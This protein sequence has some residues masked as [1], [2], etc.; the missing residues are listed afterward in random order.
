MR[1][2]VVILV[3]LAACGDDNVAR[4]AAA[5]PDAE[6][7]TEN[8][9]RDV[10]ETALTFDLTTR[11]ATA[12]ITL[13]PSASRV[14]S[15]EVGD[16]TIESVVGADGA[17][18]EVVT[19]PGGILHVHFPAGAEPVLDVAYT[20]TYHENNQGA[21]PT[22]G[23]TLLWPYY[24]GNLFP[25]KNRETPG[26]G[27][28]FTLELTG[29]PDGVTAV[30]PPAIAAESPSYMIAWALDAYDELPLGT[31]TAGTEVVMWHL[32][33]HA[34]AAAQGGAH[35]RDAFDWMEQNLGAYLYGGKVG[36]VSVRWGAGAFGG[37]EHHP[38]WHVGSVALG[39][40]EVNVHE[41][42]HGWFGNGVRLRCWEDFV[43]SE[44]TVTYLAA[45]V[46][47]E[48]G[49]QAL[50]DTVWA[51]YANQLASLDPGV[52]W[53]D[54][55][56]EVDILSLFSRIPYIKGAYFYLAV[57]DR[58]GADVLDD[59]IASF[60]AEFAGEAAGMQDM[61]DQIEATSGWD[62][63]ECAAKWLRAEQV[64]ADPSCL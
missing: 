25:C 4:D 24:C 48:V 53:P 60:Y 32:P 59:A 14:A 16:L 31:T 21:D 8:W 26:D 54:S 10:L 39:S 38:Y 40:E 20:F 57:A 45:H 30:Y 2:A 55:C 23:Y 9:A 44:G 17:P 28:R 5:P 64:P 15:F 34:A 12:R 42:A 47:G 46:L 37:M 18:L 33:A 22:P 49:G 63:T 50:E 52:A 1:V 62:P 29:V 56:G 35:L 3:A 27:T 58:I 7:E 61:L 51:D 13:A 43:L 41:A 11:A 36:T 6:P 19:E